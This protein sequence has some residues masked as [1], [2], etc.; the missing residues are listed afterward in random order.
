MDGR[1]SDYIPAYVFS[2]GISEDD[3][4]HY[5]T[6]CVHKKCPNC[7]R[8]VK[9]GDVIINMLDNVMLPNWTCSKCGEINPNWWWDE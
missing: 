7:G 2:I 9:E 1:M 5:G 8:F 3:H 6:L 4:D